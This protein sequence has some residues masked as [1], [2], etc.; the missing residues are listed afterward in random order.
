MAALSPLR[1]PW[2]DRSQAALVR[3][4]RRD[5]AALRHRPRCSVAAGDLPDAWRSGPL[6]RRSP[7][8]APARAFADVPSALIDDL[9]VLRLARRPAAWGIGHGLGDAFGQVRGP[10][11]ARPSIERRAAWGC[12][13]SLA[14]EGPRPSSSPPVS[15]G[16]TAG[17]PSGPTTARARPGVTA[18]AAG[19]GAESPAA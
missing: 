17:R 4:T 19:A 9:R 1:S 18:R 13:R 10:A 2:E 14:P 16:E 8:R 15:N 5:D 12:G 11:G 3:R 6:R 7:L